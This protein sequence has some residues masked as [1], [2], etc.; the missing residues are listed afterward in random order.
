[1]GWGSSEDKRLGIWMKERRNF[2]M[3]GGS[4][5]RESDQGILEVLEEKGRE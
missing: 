4:K 1:M 2:K 3:K 5:D